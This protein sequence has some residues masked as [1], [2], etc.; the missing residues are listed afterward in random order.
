MKPENKKRL[1]IPLFFKITTIFIFIIVL[2]LI[3]QIYITT[4]F[5]QR[6]IESEV[7]DQAM[8]LLSSLEWAVAPLIENNNYNAV[9]RLI[10]NI[11]SYKSVKLLRVYTADFTVTASNNPFERGKIIE[12]RVVADIFT[13]NKLKEVFKD[14]KNNKWLKGELNG[15]KN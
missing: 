1:F 15:T 13:G 9:Q 6:R 8:L 11:G 3:A 5:S 2:T 10:E 4:F 12:E 14:L 7:E